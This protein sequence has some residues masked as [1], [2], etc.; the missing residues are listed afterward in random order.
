MTQGN[1][2]KC[3]IQLLHRINVVINQEGDLDTLG[4]MATKAEQMSRVFHKSRKVTTNIAT[5]PLIVR[6]QRG[7]WRVTK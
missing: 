4:E 6:G 7:W 5:K 1:I 3:K 2:E